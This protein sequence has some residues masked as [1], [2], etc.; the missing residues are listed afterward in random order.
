MRACAGH[1][2]MHEGTCP[3]ASLCTQNVHFSMV[4]TGRGATMP[5]SKSV[6]RSGLPQLKT[7]TP[8]GHATMQKRQPMQRCGSCITRPSSRG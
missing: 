7:R 4:P 1:D 8:Y 6:G 5:V 2:Q 3:S